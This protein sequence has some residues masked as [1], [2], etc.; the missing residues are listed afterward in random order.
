MDWGLVFGTALAVHGKAPEIGEA[1]L[2]IDNENMANVLRARAGRATSDLASTWFWIKL[3]VGYISRGP[4]AHGLNW[5]QKRKKDGCGYLAEIPKMLKDLVADFRCLL[6]AE[7]EEKPHCWGPVFSHLSTAT[8]S[9][10]ITSAQELRKFIIRNVVGNAVELWRRFQD[11]GADGETTWPWRTLEFA[12]T[13]THEP[14]EAR[15]NLAGEVLSHSEYSP[16][17]FVGKLGFLFQD[18]LQTCVQEE[19]RLEASFCEIFHALREHVIGDIQGIES[20]NSVLGAMLR[21]AYVTSLDL[22]SARLVLHVSA[23]DLLDEATYT[24]TYRQL[25]RHTRQNDDRWTPLPI[26]DIPIPPPPRKILYPD[27]FIRAIALASRTVEEHVGMGDVIQVGLKG[28]ATKF[29]PVLVGTKHYKKSYGV[30]C[31]VEP[32]SIKIE[33]PFS[34][35]RLSDVIAE[36]LASP[37]NDGSSDLMLSFTLM[38]VSWATLETGTVDAVQIVA[39]TKAK[40]NP[41]ASE[42]EKFDFERE[43]GFVMEADDEGLDSDA[44]LFADDQEEHPDSALATGSNKSSV[45]E[46]AEAIL[47]ENPMMAADEAVESALLQS[48]SETA[49]VAGCDALSESATRKRRKNLG[50]YPLQWISYHCT[51]CGDQCGQFKLDENNGGRLPLW[52][53]RVKDKD[54]IW[55]TKG[56]LMTKRQCS[57]VGESEVWAMNWMQEKR[58]CCE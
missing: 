34:F 20:F 9:D 18:E 40:A 8:A 11:F 32:N 43:L 33:K 46:I 13:P 29:K 15:A 26:E 12:D 49:L 44:R 42:E 39:E 24:S 31:S 53:I 19:G 41:P 55:P 16:D 57:I 21:R 52:V 5:L 17:S 6:G 30:R 27:R 35:C 1:L 25:A 23:K 51:E 58:Q 7:S 47:A 45:V 36:G 50:P 37:A 10:P 4:L 54:G 14:D 38:D 48:A 56:P 3:L 22:L 2:D 28:H